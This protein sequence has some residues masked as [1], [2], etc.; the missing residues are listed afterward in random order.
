MTENKSLIYLNTYTLLY[1]KIRTHLQKAFT[2]QKY[3]LSWGME[4]FTSLS[5][6]LDFLTVRFVWERANQGPG[7]CACTENISNVKAVAK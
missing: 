3:Q 1:N 2:N 4:S 6:Q 7:P 5:S